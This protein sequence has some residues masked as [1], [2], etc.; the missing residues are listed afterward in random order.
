MGER[1]LANSSLFYSVMTTV[2]LRKLCVVKLGM[3]V[4][5]NKGEKNGHYLSRFLSKRS[6]KTKI[7]LNLC[8][9]DRAS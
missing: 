8:S 2:Q 5:M 9:S 7:E 3:S 1:N 6:K 4:S